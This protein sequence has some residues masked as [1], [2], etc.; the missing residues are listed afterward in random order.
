MICSYTQTYSD[1]RVELCEFHNKDSSD[2]R[3]RNKLDNNYF[4][5]HNSTDTYMRTVCE[6]KYFKAIEKKTL[7]S[8]N[9]MSYT[10]SL[11]K[12]FQRMKDDGY[13]YVVFLQDDA[14]CTSD[15][16]IIDELV[17]YIRHNTFDMLNLEITGLTPG[18]TCI[19]SRGDLQV[20][21]TTS[22][23]F[24]AKNLWSFD[25]GPYVANIDFMMCRVFDAVHL[26]KNDIW[27]AEHYI[28]HKIDCAPIQRLT[29]N[30]VMFK[31]FDI[32]G[33]NAWNRDVNRTNLVHN[34][35]QHKLSS[36]AHT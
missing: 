10:E 34:L 21:N 1:N 25:D 8:Y 26:S 20:Y 29:T 22:D 23:D 33:P 2:I 17:G 3:F 31:R 4:A 11:Y 7:L 13:T 24:K 35:F 36:K 12:T 14:F 15:N 16:H 6:F 9:D 18:A 30:Y 32:V 5:F 19:Y 27:T 28:R